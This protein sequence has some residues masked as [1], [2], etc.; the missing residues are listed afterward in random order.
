MFSR[1]FA[2]LRFWTVI[3]VVAAL[4][5]V[6][7][8]LTVH[9]PAPGATIEKHPVASCPMCSE[10]VLVYGIRAMEEK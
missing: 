7:K 6:V 9:V 2:A 8:P 3:A 5:A 4:V 10:P 1:H